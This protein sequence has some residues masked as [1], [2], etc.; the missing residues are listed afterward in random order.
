MDVRH[1]ID[2]EGLTVKVRAGEFKDCLKVL[3]SVA[4]P[5]FEN[6]ELLAIR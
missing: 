5:D 4:G 6:T 2:A 1:S 3:T